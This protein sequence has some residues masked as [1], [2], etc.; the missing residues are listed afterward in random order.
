MK[1]ILLVFNIVFFSGF[2]SLAQQF[3]VTVVIQNGPEEERINIV[4]VGDGYTA[5]EI[6]KFRTDVANL[7]AY[8][9]SVSPL[10]EYKQFF[11]VFG[12]EVPSNESGANHPKDAADEPGG[13]AHPELEVD[14]YFGSKFDFNGIHRLLYVTK[15][16]D[17]NKVAAAS[18][19]LYDQVFVLVNSPFYGGAGGSF[20]V[21]STNNAA[22]EVIVHEMGHSFAKLADEYGGNGG[23]LSPRES[24]NSTAETNRDDIKWKNWIENS[25]PIPTPAVSA[26]GSVVGLFEGAV[27]T[28]NDW[29]RPMLNC[30]MRSLGKKFCA[31][32]KESFVERIHTLLPISTS[33]VPA[34]SRISA[35]EE[36]LEFTVNLVDENLSSQT[37]KWYLDDQLLAEKS[38]ALS[39]DPTGLGNCEHVLRVE[40][41]DSSAFV[42][43][44][45]HAANHTY[46]K[47]WIIDLSVDAP[48]TDLVVSPDN[49]SI[50]DFTA[51]SQL[52]SLGFKDSSTYKYEYKWI[53]SDSILSDKA[54]LTVFDNQLNFDAIDTLK[55]EV[56]AVLRSNAGCTDSVYTYNYSWKLNRV[57]GTTV[58]NSKKPAEDDL[59]YF[60]PNPVQ[61]SFKLTIM[62]S[63]EHEVMLFDLEGKIL[64]S[65]FVTG[66][67]EISMKQLPSGNYFLQIHFEGTQVVK[68]LV[69]L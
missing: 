50:I 19:P 69:K 41:T 64:M 23:G 66:S 13:D 31:V 30:K 42:R 1:K 56:S 12:I 20:A 55:A 14:N 68:K 67:E 17:V 33:Y 65:T 39:I 34:Q 63:K 18:V 40:L 35:G 59:V 5:A 26:N 2:L 27:Y 44:D 48:D 32:C 37:F 60:A 47:E 24:D 53:L 25:T 36:Q 38:S 52:F 6:P 62:D 10:K 9:F 51:A 61:E 22:K 58:T 43:R 11:N 57:D 21:A 45:D 16:S 46:K 7:S 4:F 15:G 8:M 28:N 54:Q 3:P 49:K 29:Y